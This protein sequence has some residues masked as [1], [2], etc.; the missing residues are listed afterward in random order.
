[1]FKT[2]S[3]ESILRVFSKALA[4]LEAH[5]LACD[6]RKQVAEEVSRKA[7]IT[8]DSETAEA[9]RARTIHAKLT[10]LVDGTTTGTDKE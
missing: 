3:I 6:A 1:M 10:E 5:A 8:V 4:D 2:V 7:L 9:A